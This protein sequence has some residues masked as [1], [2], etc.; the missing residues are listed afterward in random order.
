M[1]TIIEHHPA[2]DQLILEVKV[3]SLRRQCVS[4]LGECQ[5]VSGDDSDC[6][7]GKQAANHTFRADCAIVGICTVKDFVQKKENGKRFCE[8]HDL[9]QPLNLGVETRCSG[10]Q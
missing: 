5:I 2:I 10:L 9:P 1:Q 4:Q 8:I 6:A 7:A 3:G